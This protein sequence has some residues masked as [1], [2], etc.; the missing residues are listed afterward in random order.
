MTRSQIERTF[1]NDVRLA[2]D[3]AVPLANER[4]E[5]FEA[6]FFWPGHR[7]VVEIDTYLTHGDR[8]TFER[9]RRKQTAYAR[10]GIMTLR[11][12]EET[13]S[14]AVANVRAVISDRAGRL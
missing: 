14:Q 12:T 2:A 13:L 1:L 6:D 9:D 8:I 4:V 11:I 7:L 5:G 3:I 10:A